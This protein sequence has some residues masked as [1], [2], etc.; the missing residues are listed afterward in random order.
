MEGRAEG[1]E[2]KDWKVN[3]EQKMENQ[4]ARKTRG[5]STGGTMDMNMINNNMNETACFAGRLPLDPFSSLY[6]I[7][8]VLIRCARGVRVSVYCIDYTCIHQRF[9]SAETDQESNAMR[10]ANTQPGLMPAILTSYF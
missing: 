10:L 7:A 8:V 1:R 9:L 3:L 4:R 6:H 5:K 2:R